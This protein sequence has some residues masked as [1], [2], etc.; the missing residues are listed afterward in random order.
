[1]QKTKLKERA[2]HI[3]SSVKKW[4]KKRNGHV[5]R[6]RRGMILRVFVTVSA[7]VLLAL[8][9]YYLLGFFNIVEPENISNL[10][11]IASLIISCII[12]ALVVSYFISRSFEKPV[13]NS[14][15][16]IN[17]LAEGDYSVR[18]NTNKA[19]K[20]L[21][22]L[23]EAINKTA[24]ELGNTEVMRN[25]FLNTVSH[26]YKTPVSSI[27]G[28]ANI[29]KSTDLTK[30]QQ[31]YVDIII[32]ESHHLSTMTTNVLLL[33]KFE[34]T[35]I[36]TGK[37]YFSLDEQLRNCFQSLQNEWL[38][39]DISISGEFNGVTYYGNKEILSHV[40]TNIIKN[41]IKF[42]E[43][44]GEIFCCVSEKDNKA[45][46]SIKDN[47]CGMDEETVSRIFDK[48]YQKDKSGN[49]EGN[50]LGLSIV[51]RIVDLCKG[52]I[53]VNSQPDV[54]TE[55]IVMLPEEAAPEKER[56]ADD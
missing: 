6:A 20:E 30:E 47:G 14:V 13:E 22:G 2:S 40:W 32:A 3:K 11:I 42:T 1:M 46:V 48:F 53:I 52:E 15:E 34:N 5:S 49:Q 29:L 35:E 50:G 33:N 55:F 21:K 9:I 7:A 12:V 45:I 43:R 41:A 4:F 36:I 18:L 25:D 8:G 37:Q 39:K 27:L 26:E 24:E 28:Y 54:G 10:G 19:N 23:M 17:S 31:G 56:E 51:K 44:G 38:G 16:A